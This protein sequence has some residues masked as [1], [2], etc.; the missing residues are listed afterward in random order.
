MWKQWRGL[1]VFFEKL[2]SPLNTPEGFLWKGLEVTLVQILVI[3]ATTQEGDFKLGLKRR[4]PRKQNVLWAE[5]DKGF[6]T[7]LYIQEWVD[8]NLCFEKKGKDI[9]FV[10]KKKCHHKEREI[11]W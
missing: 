7:M 8:P 9:L 11:H 2:P 4:K 3:V 1:F 5:V 10:K 6:L